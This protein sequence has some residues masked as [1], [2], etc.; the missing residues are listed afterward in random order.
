M[1]TRETAR[2][3]KD[4]AKARLRYIHV[5][6]EYVGHFDPKTGLFAGWL[7]LPGK[8][9]DVGRNAAKRARAAQEWAR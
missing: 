6:K 4:A 9:Y 8:T 1:Y 7:P 2:Q 5:S 3:R